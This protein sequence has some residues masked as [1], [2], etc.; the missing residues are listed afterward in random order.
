MSKATGLVL[1]YGLASALPLLIAFSV[2]NGVLFMLLVP[3]PLFLSGLSM[4]LAA[5]TLST[6]TACLALSLMIAAAAMRMSGSLAL[7]L[8][9]GAGMFIG[10]GITL[11]VPVI[12]LVRQALFNRTAQDGSVEWY[13]AGLLVTWLTGAG[14]FLLA[15]TL[16]S[17]LW[18]ASGPSLEAIFASQLSDALRLVLPTVEDAHL[19]EAAAAAAR[20]GLG[21][22]LDS[23]LMVI[24]ANGILAQGV[25][26]RF[27]RNLRPAPDITQLDLPTWLGLALAAAVLVAWLA[28]GDVGFL[29]LSLAIVLVVPFFFAGLA[30][31]HAACRHRGSR[32]IMLIIFYLILVLFFW[33]ATLVAGLGLLDQTIGLRRRLLAA[34]GKQENE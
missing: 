20:Y 19:Q 16:V 7:A 21:I 22:G 34:A 1:L 3:L 26:G 29:A 25:L 23:W 14:L 13:P 8:A 4:G 30:V 11:G 2:P 18:F 10:T 5:V 33:P 15:F 27:G 12:V 17:L 28:P 31:V 32:A 24:A 9:D 6:A